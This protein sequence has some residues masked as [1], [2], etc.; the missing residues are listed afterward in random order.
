MELLERAIQSLAGVCDYANNKDDVGFNKPDS[1][2]GHY[3]AQI[4]YRYW[5][6]YDKYSAYIMLQ[7]YQ[8]QLLTI[9]DIHYKDIPKIIAPAQNYPTRFVSMIGNN[10]TLTFP[11]NY[12]VI[13]GIKKTFR[14]RRPQ[15][16]MRGNYKHVY[17]VVE[18]TPQ[19]IAALPNFIQKHGFTYHKAVKALL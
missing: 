11:Y 8:Q 16:E 17:W 15:T 19:N 5:S 1:H 6:E 9:F 18:N 12:A 7:K 3:L 4:P 10:F 14:N 13:D 2:L